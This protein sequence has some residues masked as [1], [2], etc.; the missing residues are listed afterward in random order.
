[1]NT[2]SRGE[3]LPSSDLCNGYFAHP[4]LKKKLKIS[5]RYEPLED[6][7]MIEALAPHTP[8]KAFTDG[9]R[10]RDVIGRFEHTDATRVCDTS[11]VYPK[12]AI[13]TP[14]KVFDP[15][16]IGGGFSQLLRDP[17][18]VRKSYD[19]HMDHFARVQFDDEEY[20][21]QAKEQVSDRE[22]VTV[23]SAIFGL[24][25]AALDLYFQ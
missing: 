4:F 10:S 22:E 19:A 25:A 21:V 11:E 13:V 24:G 18:V 12:L 23:S 9:I 6:K 14:K 16:A 17:S 5:A 2:L 3:S 20:K 8:K 1:M 15:L 7:Q